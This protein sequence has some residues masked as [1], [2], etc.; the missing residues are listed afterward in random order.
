M[1]IDRRDPGNVQAMTSE[2]TRR[3]CIALALMALAC[4]SPEADEPA[5]NS[6]DAG[7]EVEDS[8]SVDVTDC[9]CPK[10]TQ[11]GDDGGCVPPD[12][13][14]VGC[15]W[16][17]DVTATLHVEAGA[18]GDGS[19]QAPFGALAPALA[20]AEAGDVVFVRPGTYTGGVTVPSGVSLIGLCPDQI[21]VTGPAAGVAIATHDSADV[22]IE[23]LLVTDAA[24]GIQ[25]TGATDLWIR[26]N[27]LQSNQRGIDLQGSSALVESVTAS[28]S[29]EDPA[30]RLSLTPGYG[31]SV[32]KQ[33]NVVLSAVSVDGSARTGL[34]VDDS[35]IGVFGGAFSANT[36]S[37]M[38][39]Q[40]NVSGVIDGATVSKA[41]LAGGAGDGLVLLDTAGLEIRNATFEDNPRHSIA[42]EGGTG[43]VI[44]NNALRGGGEG[45]RVQHT[46]VEKPSSETMTS[47]RT[48]A[49]AS[50]LS[51]A[52]PRSVPETRFRVRAWM[53]AA[54][55][56]TGST[57]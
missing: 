43:V 39:L 50:S 54:T 22:R 18:D 32:I 4:S 5:A 48:V 13:Q 1:R 8:S 34:T 26:R 47:R 29:K 41:K 45:I 36:G 16:P 46:A 37:N 35:T 7:P 15:E 31:I 55:L 2:A 21:T 14:T 40:T 51:K 33:S 6:N 11:C 42:V 56:A 10:P 44:R 52:A 53:T 12:V 49:A 19:E 3:L 23:G 24:I 38:R 28:G 17:A 9:P 25:A 30:N 27:A 57:S 20:A